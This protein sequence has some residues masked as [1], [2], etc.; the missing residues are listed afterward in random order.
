VDVGRDRHAE[1]LANFSKNAAT[2]TR[3]GSAKRAD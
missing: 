2:L 3:A 1:L